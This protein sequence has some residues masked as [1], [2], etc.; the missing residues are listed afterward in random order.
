[1]TMAESSL[2]QGRDSFRRQAWGDAFTLLSA[3]DC[4]AS[5]DVDDLE[6]LATTAYLIGRE[7]DGADILARAYHECLRLDDAVRAARCAFW[8]GF[9]LANLGE[10][11]RGRGWLARAQR[12]IDDGRHDCVEQ[13]YLL[14]PAALQRFDAGDTAGAYATFAQIATIAERF[15]DLNLQTLAGLGRGHTLIRLGETANGLA[16]LDE[17]MVAVTAGE[18]IPLVAGI[19]YCAA[20]EACQEVFD[21]RRAREWTSALSHWCASQ[22]DLVPFRGQ[23]LV[24][25]AEIMQWHGAWPDAI[26]EAQRACARLSEQAGQ[27]AIGA[28]FYRLAELHRLRGQFAKAEDAYRQAS[29]WGQAPEP[30][31]ALLRLAQGRVDVAAAAIRRALD[32]AQDRTS[33]SRLLTGHVEIMLVAGDVQAARAAAEELATIAAGLGMP[34]FSAIAAYAS[35][36]VLLRE[37]DSRGALGA[38]RDAWR[39]WQR[40]DA[41]YDAGRTRV[42]IGLAC[43]SLGD[44]DTAVMELDAARWVFRQLGAAPDLA[45][46][47]ALLKKSIATTTGGLTAREVEVLRLVAGGKTN[48]AI[49][50]E[51]IIS[52]KTVARHVSNIFTKLGLSS[53]AAATA[54]AYEHNLL[55]PTT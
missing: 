21:L 36:A 25:R 23:C 29:R 39:A 28:A 1:M 30:G 6:R 22:P 7:G 44:E 52:E 40:L 14:L 9:Q 46:V 4:E 32:E 20:I 12:L 37:G 27:P 38:L 18:V 35:G 33:R 53:R 47:E 54:Y 31:L 55:S 26:D 41:P 8:L 34:V 19:V 5:L 2:T 3:A 13:G 42:L 43:R 15:R 50:D 11:A 24:Y 51:L 16:L 45:G 17:V 49:A 48:R 10:M